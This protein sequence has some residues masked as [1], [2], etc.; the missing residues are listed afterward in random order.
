MGR[1]REKKGDL[2]I[3]LV[4]IFCGKYSKRYLEIERDREK[5]IRVGR[6]RFWF[7]TLYY[8]D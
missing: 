4:K 3:G 2:A 8:I 6:G 7:F 5:E 1:R